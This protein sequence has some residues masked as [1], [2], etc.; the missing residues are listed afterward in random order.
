MIK[1]FII[2]NL[3]GIYKHGSN[4]ILKKMLKEI[5]RL[6]QTQ[7]FTMNILRQWKDLL[8]YKDDSV[9]DMLF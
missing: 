7:E 1:T 9:V 2:H 3:N 5:R 6:K 4:Y 8:V